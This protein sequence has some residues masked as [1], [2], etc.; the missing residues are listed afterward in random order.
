MAKVKLNPVLEGIRGAIGD[1]VF[2]HHGEEVI[3]GRKP[4]PSNTP[5]TAGQQAVRERFKLAALY[6]KT[7]MADPDSKQLY[8]T[9]AKAKGIPVFAL[10]LADFFNAPAVDEIDLAAY[11]GKA[12]DPIKVR[13]HD[14]FALTGVA[15]A[16]RGTDGTVLEQGAAAAGTDGAYSYTATQTLTAGQNVVIEVTAT[17][18]PGHKTTKTQAR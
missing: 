16:I 12:G 15:V 10:A 18:R 4:D 7:V 1:L 2:R 3:V 5:P 13:A 8:T 6:G 17:D 11:T 14:D 9:A